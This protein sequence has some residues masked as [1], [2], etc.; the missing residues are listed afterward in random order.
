M[1]RTRLALC[2]AIVVSGIAAS[3]AA[4]VGQGGAG[5]QLLPDLDT[6]TP[7]SVTAATVERADGTHALLGFASEAFNVGEGPL[8]VAGDRGSVEEPTM[9]ATQVI[10]HANG[11]ESEVAGV[12]RFEYVEDPTH[13]HWHLLPFMRYE[14]R[15]PSSFKLV[16]R[17]R[18]TGFCL[19][20]R[21][22]A[23]PDTALPNEPENPV[24]RS[25]C[26]LGERQWREIEEGISVGWS[27]VYEPWR[28]GQYID[29][30]GLAPGKY[31]LVHRVNPGRRLVESNYANNASS[32]L[33]RLTWPNGSELAPR[34]TILKRCPLTARC[35]APKR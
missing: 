33:L 16:V 28:D 19:G 1:T 21:I 14:L 31:V 23:D 8:I 4:G 22:N 34:V 25:N 15:R 13:D 26:G 30:T 10:R 20:D 35:P 27:D 17:D 32:V 5:R 9:A 7:F 29:V 12:G 24:Y 11:S 2:V 3:V 18:K 6:K